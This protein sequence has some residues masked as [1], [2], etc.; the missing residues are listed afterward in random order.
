MAGWKL[1]R[2][3]ASQMLEFGLKVGRISLIRA[4]K[5]RTLL[6]SFDM[7]G[8]WTQCRH[9]RKRTPLIEDTFLVFGFFQ[10][11]VVAERA[12]SSC[13]ML[14]RDRATCSTHM[15]STCLL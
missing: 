15:L 5:P 8:M 3:S 2:M 10:D 4:S 14:C 7:V 12:V 11:D 6:L 1:S 13:I 9:H